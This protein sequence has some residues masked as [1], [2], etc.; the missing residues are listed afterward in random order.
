M[1]TTERLQL[2]PL[3]KDHIQDLEH[4]FCK[5]EL[6]M[7][8]TFKGRVFTKKE[9][10]DTLK[11]GFIVSED[12]QVGFWCLTLKGED[13]VIGI[14]GLLACTYLDKADYEFGFVLNDAHWGKGFATELGQFWLT[15]AKNK[16]KLKALIAVVSPQNMASRRVLEK[17]QM[18][19]VRQVKCSER[20]DRLVLR[21][22]L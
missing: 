22:E 4:L 15:Y 9:F 8:N 21:K 13:K 5:N 16:M 7:Q 17:L 19:F 3:H 14:T 20:G 1:L 10:E 18:K 11:T 2:K 6:V 12:E